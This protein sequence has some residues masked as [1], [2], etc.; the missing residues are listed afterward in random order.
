MRPSLE[1]LN[2]NLFLFFDGW[3][4][5]GFGIFAFAYSISHLLWMKGSKQLEPVIKV[6]GFSH[7]YLHFHF[8][9]MQGGLVALSIAFGTS[10]VTALLVRMPFATYE[11]SR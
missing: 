5:L 8:V 9:R 10:M 2:Q 11:E 1:C 7:S 3:G 6:N 4:M